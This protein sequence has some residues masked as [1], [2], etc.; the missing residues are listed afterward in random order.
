MTQTP[1]KYLDLLEAGGNTS[2]D[3]GGTSGSVYDDSFAFPK[4]RAM[5]LEIK[6]TSSGTVNLD[7][8]LEQGNEE[9]TDAQEGSSNADYVIPEGDSLLANISATGTIILPLGPTVSRFARVRFDKKTGN[10]ATTTV[11][12]LR[13]TTS[14]N[15]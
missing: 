8:Y 2:I 7:V 14:E 10:D 13:V 6:I 5:G 4:N 9:L 3:V 12:R 1:I 11:T 15:A